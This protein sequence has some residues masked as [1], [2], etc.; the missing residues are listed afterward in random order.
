MANIHGAMLVC[1]K[2]IRARWEQLATNRA[3][4]DM[5]CAESGDKAAA[6]VASSPEK[7]QR[8]E[9]LLADNRTLLQEIDRQYQALFQIRNR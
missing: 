5:L 9:Q 6:G 8:F 1:E 4:L 2:R 7:R 3:E